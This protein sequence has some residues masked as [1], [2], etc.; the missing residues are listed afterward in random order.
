MDTSFH[1]LYNHIKTLFNQYAPTTTEAAP[2][3]PTTTMA[4]K[5]ETAIALSERVSVTAKV[6]KT[7]S[8][9]LRF[10]REDRPRVVLFEHA[11]RRLKQVSLQVTAI[12]AGNEANLLREWLLNDSGKVQQKL[13][14]TTYK[15]VM[16]TGIH[17]F[18]ENG[19]RIRGRAI[20]LRNDEWMRLLQSVDELDAAMNMCVDAFFQEPKDPKTQLPEEEGDEWESHTRRQSWEES[21]PPRDSYWIKQLKERNSKVTTNMSVVDGLTISRSPWVGFSNPGSY[22]FTIAE[23]GKTFTSVEADPERAYRAHLDAQDR[24]I[25]S[26]LGGLM[27]S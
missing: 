5:N 22:S 20:N 9:Y 7:G 24:M 2:A 17:S 8:P 4:T 6:A 26:G 18:D 23:T 19:E 3:L 16:Y 13:L 10:E 15:D 1:D 27:F 11:W 14:M 12:F 21:L 25:K